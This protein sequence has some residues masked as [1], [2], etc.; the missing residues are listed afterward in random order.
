MIKK[1]FSIV[2]RMNRQ[3]LMEFSDKKVVGCP[4]CEFVT[5]NKRILN[6]HTHQTHEKDFVALTKMTSGNST[7]K[8]ADPEIFRCLS[9]LKG[10]QHIR[11]LKEHVTRVHAVDKKFV[12]TIC[13]KRFPRQAC[14]K[15]HTLGVHLGISLKRRR[16]S[17]K[18]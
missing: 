10:F 14:L 17:K 9:C 15:R 18:H 16:D 3:K 4:L 1:S 5:S 8:K 2:F 7:I 11:N 13:R 6:I 12:C